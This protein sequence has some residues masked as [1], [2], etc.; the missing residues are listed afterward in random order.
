MKTDSDRLTVLIDAEDTMSDLKLMRRHL[1]SA[2]V[3]A[4]QNKKVPRGLVERLKRDFDDINE[5]VGMAND[6]LVKLMED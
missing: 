2:T 1:R 3:T 5:L 4:A 6:T